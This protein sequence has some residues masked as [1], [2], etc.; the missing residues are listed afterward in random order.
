MLDALTLDQL[1]VLV[2]V[3]DVGSF[4]AAA[5]RVRRVQSAISKSIRTLEEALSIQVFDRAG[6]YPALRQ[7]A[8]PWSTTR[9]SSYE[10]PTP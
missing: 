5:R 1:R 3:A 6:K 7:P 10:M 8:R 2:M 4:S 9:E